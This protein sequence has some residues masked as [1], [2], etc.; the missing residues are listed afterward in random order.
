[1]KKPCAMPT[2]GYVDIILEAAKKFGIPTLNLY[3]DLGINPNIPEDYKKYTIDGL[4]FNDAAHIIM[5][6][7]LK[8]LLES[9]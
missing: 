4:H 5:A 6:E 3:D 9:L 7:K 8:E 1:M 2:K